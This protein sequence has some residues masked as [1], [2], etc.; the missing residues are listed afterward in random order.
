MARRNRKRTKVN[1]F[2]FPVPFAGLLVLLSI[3][4]LAYVWVGCRCEALGRE[5][6]ALEFRRDALVKK[7]LNEE[8]KWTQMKSPYNIERVLNRHRIEMSWPHRHQVVR[9]SDVAL[10]QAELAET[11]GDFLKLA[12]LEKVLIE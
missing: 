6:K 8:Y 3:L 10:L 1:G 2:I 9:L 5:L 12:K 11:T 4:G 7:Y